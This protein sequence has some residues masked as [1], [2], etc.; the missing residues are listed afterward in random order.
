MKIELHERL[1]QMQASSSIFAVNGTNG[2]E[3]GI[4]ALID[5]MG[6]HGL[7][8]YQSEIST[9][10]QGPAGLFNAN[11]TIII[12]VNGQWNERGGTNTDLIKSIL[13]AIVRHPDRFNGEIIIADNGQGTGRGATG[14]GGSFTWPDNNAMDT[15]QSIQKV[16]NSLCCSSNIST[17]LWDNIAFKRVSEYS[18]GDEEDGYVIDMVSNPRTGVMV[19][20]PK[21]KTEFGTFISFKE[22]VWNPDTKSYYS[23]RLKIINMPTLKSHSSFG[24]TCCTK[25]YMGV[26]TDR[27][28]EELGTRTHDTVG[29][30]GMGTAKSIL[31]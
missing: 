9:R 4:T 21:F 23:S 7:P 6:K 16:V 26:C 28:T 17:Y 29:T 30:G 31:M 11:D 2:D 25:H 8:F 18:D 14:S 12:K 27:L 24:A 3:R 13:E 10:N 15:S 22:G 1:S 20:Y 19:S 5:L